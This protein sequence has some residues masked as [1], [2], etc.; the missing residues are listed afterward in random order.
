MNS[1]TSQT[2]ISRNIY[3]NPLIS[4]QSHFHFQKRLPSNFQENHRGRFFGTIS[5]AF[6]GSDLYTRLIGSDLDLII[7]VWI[8]NLRLYFF[9]CWDWKHI[10]T[11]IHCKKR[12]SLTHSMCRKG[13]LKLAIFHRLFIPHSRHSKH[14]PS[15]ASHKSRRRT[16]RKSNKEPKEENERKRSNPQS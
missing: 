2:L 6:F 1:S 16:S 8:R 7:N 15:S 5:E 3:A 14:P 9:C 11:D 12:Q 10:R 13:H 4:D